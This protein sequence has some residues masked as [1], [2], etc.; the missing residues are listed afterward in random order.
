MQEY[1]AIVKRAGDWWIGWIDEVP[2]VNCQERSREELLRTLAITLSEALKLV[3][4]QRWQRRMRA[5]RWR[6]SSSL[7]EAQSPSAASLKTGLGAGARGAMAFS[8]AEPRGPGSQM[9]SGCQSPASAFVTK[10]VLGRM[11]RPR[12]QSMSWTRVPNES[13][14][15][16]LWRSST[17]PS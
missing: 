17:S 12:S 2:G 9:P 10:C 11:S 7:R 5:T 16:T 8:V 1:T 6:R 3:A 4:R 15:G 14:S 13:L